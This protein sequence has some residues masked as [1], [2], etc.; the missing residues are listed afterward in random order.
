MSKTQQLTLVWSPAS[1]RDVIRLHDF[2]KSKNLNA[3]HRAADKIRKTAQLILNNPAIGHRLENREDREFFT[4]F[5][6]N[7]YIFRY[8]VTDN[9]VVILKIWHTRE[10]PSIN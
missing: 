3:A 9:T 8:R 4:P 5:G 1:T 10:M 7:G 2:L 6:K